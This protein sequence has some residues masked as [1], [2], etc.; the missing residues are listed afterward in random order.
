M[1]RAATTLADPCT[2]ARRRDFLLGLRHGQRVGAQIPSW[3]SGHGWTAGCSQRAGPPGQLTAL[4][5]QT[6]AEGTG[7][8]LVAP[9]ELARLA[10]LQLL[11]TRQLRRVPVDRPGRFLLLLLP[12]S[13]GRGS[14]AGRNG[15][16]RASV[17]LNAH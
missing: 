9:N 7:G 17:I 11:A 8:R 16:Q 1:T 2:G 13:K 12:C 15:A 4:S 14:A 5:D 6:A 10:S 3:C